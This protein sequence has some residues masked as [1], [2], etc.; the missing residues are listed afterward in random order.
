MRK[1]A[2]APNDDNDLGAMVVNNFLGRR[3][4]SH[5]WVFLGDI[6][7]MISWCAAFEFSKPTI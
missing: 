4:Q 1:L 6:R 5:D 2:S 7:S 3:G